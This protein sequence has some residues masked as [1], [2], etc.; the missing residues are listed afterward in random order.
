ME[1]PL[2]QHICNKIDSI[3]VDALLNRI[4]A[5]APVSVAAPTKKKV[6]AAAT[7][8]TS[9]RQAL[10]AKTEKEIEVALAPPPS[11]PKTNNKRQKSG[12][13]YD[14]FQE[15][16]RHA[17]NG[18]VGLVPSSFQHTTWEKFIETPEYAALQHFE[19]YMNVLLE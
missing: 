7:I 18:N 10:D 2:S 14:W 19:A 15:W 8:S 5:P 9:K 11:A 4:G 12:Y 1:G 6:A 16:N 3:D 17:K 13:L